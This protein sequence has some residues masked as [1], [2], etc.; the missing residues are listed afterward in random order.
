[1]VINSI[2]SLGMVAQ[3]MWPLPEETEALAA[4]TG[5]SPTVGLLGLA[6]TATIMWIAYRNWGL[7]SAE[8]PTV[9]PA[10]KHERLLTLSLIMVIGMCSFGMILVLTNPI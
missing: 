1:M 10:T 8:Q 9:T 5:I 3:T 2:A 6:L 4:S 7:P